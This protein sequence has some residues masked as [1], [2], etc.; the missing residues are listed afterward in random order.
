MRKPLPTPRKIFD[1]EGE[2]QV[3]A[4][5]TSRQDE[6]RRCIPGEPVQ[7]RLVAGGAAS[8]E[9]VVVLSARGVPIGRLTRQYAALL[10]P[11]L[12]AGRPHRAKLHCLRGGLA[13][14]PL[15]G[16]RISIAWDGRPEHPH[17]PLDEEQLRYRERSAARRSARNS[18]PSSGSN[19]A[20]RPALALADRDT[21]R[22]ALFLLAAIVFALLA[23]LFAQRLGSSWC[24][25]CGS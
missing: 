8:P 24:W 4:D 6:L 11:L 18:L 12:E 25:G 13:G 3:N 21:T 1:L 20:F 19:A 16:A 5:G 14:Y 2:A 15:Y 23:L 10:S 9:E 7:L 22:I 17:R